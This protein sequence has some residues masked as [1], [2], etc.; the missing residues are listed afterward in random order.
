LPNETIAA[1]NQQFGPAAVGA[2]PPAA[3]WNQ[4]FSRADWLSSEI[5]W[6]PLGV[7]PLPASSQRD[8]DQATND[9]R[10]ELFALLGADFNWPPK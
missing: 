8:G 3:W 10:D 9:D 2:T 7:A 1:P 6:A 4:V 5:D